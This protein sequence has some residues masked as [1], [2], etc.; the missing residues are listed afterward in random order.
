MAAEFDR[1][2]DRY[3]DL[4]EQS[5]A[6]SGR[7]HGFFV[8]MKALRLLDVARRRL[9]DAARIRALDVGCGLGLI[10]PYL[11]ELGQLE[12]VDLS[13]EMV[14]AARERNPNVDY[15]VGSGARLPFPDES[16]DLVFTI[17]T[18]HH[19][20]PRERAPF[21]AEMR[22]VTR[23]GG[24]VVVFEHNPFNPLTRLAVSRCAFDEDAILLTKRELVR[25]LSVE[26]LVPVEHAYLLFFPSRRRRFLQAERA[27]ARVPLGAQYYVAAAPA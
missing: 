25:R 5:I 24:L 16:F 15:R 11:R 1:Y 23:A 9:G 17:A 19:V 6:F 14:D 20:P 26:R 21:L 7:E 10:H 3:S 12:G 4:V 8:E 22:R 27:L 2:A 13:Q 18:L